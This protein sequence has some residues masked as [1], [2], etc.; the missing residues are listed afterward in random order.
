ME[1]GYVDINNQCDTNVIYN[2]YK[3][4]ISDFIGNT[5]N[6]AINSLSIT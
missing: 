4:K 3:F 1:Y 6:T 2:D 5:G